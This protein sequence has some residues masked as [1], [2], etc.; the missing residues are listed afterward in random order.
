MEFFDDQML[1]F[2]LFGVVANIVMLVITFVVTLLKTFALS[3]ADLQ[4]FAQFG[5]T[6]Q[7][8]I[9]KHNSSLK[10]YAA[11][12]LNIVP[13]YSAIIH[14]WFLLHILIVPGLRGLIMGTMKADNLAWIQL[15]KYEIVK[16]DK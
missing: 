10:I 1:D 7:Y 3:E 11:F 14:V 6:R 5:R 16:V 13:L 4:Q 2:M 8:L 9:L 12:L 15:V